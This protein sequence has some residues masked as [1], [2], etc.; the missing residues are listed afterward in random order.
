[1]DIEEIYVGQK[2]EVNLSFE[3]VPC[4]QCGLRPTPCMAL[5]NSGLKGVVREKGIYPMHCLQCGRET[6]DPGI[7]VDL[8][9]GPPVIGN[10]GMPCWKVIVNPWEL[11]PLH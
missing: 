4:P 6:L 10:N 8:R 1:M 3:A 2:V 11:S 9:G 5:A 7:L